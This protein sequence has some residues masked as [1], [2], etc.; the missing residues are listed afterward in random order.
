MCLLA[1][2]YLVSACGAVIVYWPRLTQPDVSGRWEADRHLA[3]WHVPPLLMALLM[4]QGVVRRRD[5]RFGL[6]P[7]WLDLVLYVLVFALG[8]AGIAWTQRHPLPH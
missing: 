7:R 1:C 4:L 2:L 6:L 8:L 3:A 5:G